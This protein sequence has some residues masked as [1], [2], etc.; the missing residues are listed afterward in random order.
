MTP[1]EMIKFDARV[2]I[3]IRGGKQLEL[4]LSG[5][6][7]EPLIDIDMVKGIRTYSRTIVYSIKLF[8]VKIRKISI[9]VE[10]FR[11]LRVSYHLNC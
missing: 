2:M 11:E 9:L 7:E 6:S 4:R 8:I 1:Q 10:Y 5:E 3:Q